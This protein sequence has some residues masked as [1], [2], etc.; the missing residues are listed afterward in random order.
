MKNGDLQLRDLGS[1]SSNVRGTVDSR[2][3][4]IEKSFPLL[5]LDQQQLTK[6]KF[7]PPSILLQRLV[8][9][10]TTENNVQALSRLPFIEYCFATEADIRVLVADAA[11]DSI[12]ILQQLDP[13]KFKNLS[14]RLE[15]SFLSYRPDA[16][17]VRYS[18]V[19]ICA[20]EIKKPIPN[21]ESFPY[22]RTQAFNNLKLIE[23]FGHETPVVVASSFDQSFAC[24]TAEEEV[25]QAA[26]GNI[27][28]PKTTQLRTANSAK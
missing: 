6:L 23:A 15:M 11:K 3:R 14:Y 28:P 25:S 12:A 10:R 26:I 27:P 22:V 1:E 13:N 7:G 19:P 20:L 8:D 17:I 9:Q 4:T 2:L 18:N 24:W 5:K 16:V 21:L